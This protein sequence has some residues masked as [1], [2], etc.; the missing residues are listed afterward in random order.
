MDGLDIY[1]IHT[2]TDS[3]ASPQKSSPIDEAHKRPTPQDYDSS[4]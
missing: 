1:G 4:L 3:D 2:S